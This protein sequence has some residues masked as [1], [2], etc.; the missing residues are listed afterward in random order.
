MLGKRIAFA[1][2]R[3]GVSQEV[4]A[5]RLGVT[6]A[7][8]GAYEQG[9]RSPSA[10]MLVSLSR[11]LGVSVDFML[12]GKPLHLGEIGTAA[13]YALQR[14]SLDGTGERMAMAAQM[15]LLLTENCKK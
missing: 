8:V 1:R 9:R 11:I 6:P 4:L 13:E 2:R 5:N 10:A 7:A 15:L 12:T 3:M 14:Q